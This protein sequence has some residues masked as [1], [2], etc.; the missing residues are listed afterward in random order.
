MAQQLE[1]AAEHDV[2]VLGSGAAGLVAALA[3]S[4]AGADV[5]VYEKASHIGGTTAVSGG[6]VWIPANP[7]QAQLGVKDTVEDGIRYL[8]SLS[9]GLLDEEMVRTLVEAGPGVVSWLERST[10]LRLQVIEGY[11]D[12]QPEHPGGLPGGG[13]S[14]ECPLFSFA[15]LGEWASAVLKPA[16]AVNVML[17]EL[18]M[19][20]GSGLVAEET[21][22]A[23]RAR[24]Q[25]GIGQGIIGALLAGCLQRSIEPVR[26][27]RALELLTENGRVCGVRM[28][29]EGAAVQVRARRG[30]VLATGGFERDP[31]LVRSFLRGPMTAP[32][33]AESNTGDGLKMAMRL[34]AALGNMREAWWVPVMHV[35]DPDHGTRS[36]LVNRERT[37]P[38]SILVNRAGRRFVNEA[39][40]YNALGG[41]FHT[42]DAASFDYPNVPCWLIFDHEYLQRYGVGESSPSDQP[43]EWVLSAG[44]LA[45]LA[46]MIGVEVGGLL[47]TVA[48]FNEDVAAGRDQAFGRGES[49]Y[50]HWAGDRSQQGTRRTLGPLEEA[51]F[52]AIE[53][54][55]G[56]L[57]TSGGPRTDA[58]ARVLDVDG[59]VIEGLFAAGNV[60]AGPTGMAYGGAGG[61]LGPAIVFGYIAGTQ[62]AAAPSDGGAG[63]PA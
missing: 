31:E 59:A 18:P 13:R 51:P 54:H 16:R 27:A 60:M 58:K 24:D 20:G 10:P 34:G 55:P 43:P 49:A 26:N 28:Q 61:T 41:A 40:N 47:E 3:A 1:T 8:M 32:T 45:E 15:E 2:I 12:Y 7:H 46:D 44:T 23:R 9:H 14:L 6:M 25:R 56:C 21:L 53:I 17:H 11:P 38:R 35:P 33:G 50:D 63:G 52:H 48:S 57:G 42:F 22:Q 30:V 4:D 36:L 19:G 62:S 37:L 39:S 29:I 5:Q